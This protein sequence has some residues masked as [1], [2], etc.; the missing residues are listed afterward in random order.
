MHVVGLCVHIQRDKQSFINDLFQSAL[1]MKDLLHC[2]KNMHWTVVME[3]FTLVKA[4]Y[5][6]TKRKLKRL[7]NDF[8]HYNVSKGYTDRPCEITESKP[9]TANC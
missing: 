3:M 9:G 2:I 5:T 7:E 8:L 6:K 4:S 1:E